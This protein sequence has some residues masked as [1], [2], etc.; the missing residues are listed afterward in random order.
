MTPGPGLH[1]DACFYEAAEPETSPFQSVFLH[2][3]C[4][5][6]IRGFAQSKGEEEDDEEE[7]EEDSVEEEEAEEEDNEAEEASSSLDES[8]EKRTEETLSPVSL[9]MN[10]RMNER[11]TE[12]NM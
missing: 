2:S 6:L 8:T 10:E 7:K 12:S 9:F 3:S 4:Q 11:M 5:D 1:P